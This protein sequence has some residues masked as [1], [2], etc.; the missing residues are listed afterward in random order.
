VTLGWS[1]S[2]DGNVIGYQLY[3]GTASR[4]YTSRIAAGLNATATVSGLTAG[5]T[6]YFAVTA[7][8]TSGMESAFSN[9]VRYTPSPP[10]AR[11][12]VRSAT[13]RQVV[14]G[15]TGQFGHVY[16]VQASPDLKHWTVLGLVTLNLGVSLDFLDVSTAGQPACF[17]RLRE[18]LN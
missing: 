9:E 17:Y 12:Q 10:G 2:A 11:L 8:N 3:Y 4:R 14:L 15:I 5:T 7:V 1:P 6:Y 13:A 16:E 18:V